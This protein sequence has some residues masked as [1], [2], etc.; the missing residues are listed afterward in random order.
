MRSTY[1][2]AKINEDVADDALLE[3]GEI[4]PEYQKAKTKS[5]KRLLDQYSEMRE[6]LKSIQASESEQNDIFNHL[7][8]F[9]SRYYDNGDFIPRRRYG[10]RETY[11][12]PYNGEETVFHWA[13]RDQHYVKTGERF[14]DYAFTVDIAEATCHIRFCLTD[15]SLPPGNTKG[16]AR[17]FFPLP[18]QLTYERGDKT[19]VL[20]FHYR[21]ATE[22]DLSA[23]DNLKNSRLQEAILTAAI[24][25]ILERI[26]NAS[27]RAG[28]SAPSDPDTPDSI[29]ILEKRLRHFC[30]KNTSDYFIHKDLA[31]FLN[32]EMEFYLKDQVVHL[33][34]LEGDIQPRLRILRVIRTLAGEIITFL[35]QIEDVQKRLFEKRKLVLRA[36]YIIPI[37]EIPNAFW[38]EICSNVDQTAQWQTLFGIDSGQFGPEADAA[39]KSQFLE[40]H[41][42]LTIDTTCFNSDFTHRLLATFMDL[43]ESIDG[44]L[45][46][47]ENYQG[48][49]FLEKRY[50]GQVICVY[51]DPP[52]NT[53]SDE[54]IYKDKYRHSSWLA[55]AE[56]GWN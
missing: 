40:A 19:A 49:R 30:K 37:K 43:D 48:L 39:S 23:Y 41:P 32:R 16:D 28:L 42:T 26:D 11:A 6:K 56:E 9:F 38:P 45:I 24:P 13:N 17:Y 18:E 27:L 22:A 4:N 25:A 35:A 14:Q 1:L 36:D 34:D 10:A 55:M 33:A 20:P 8:T 21:P 2:A 50:A 31:G 54:F 51:I 46:H 53:G 29:S 52:Y 5:A 47:S 12:V 3:T 7:Y 44:L 15:A